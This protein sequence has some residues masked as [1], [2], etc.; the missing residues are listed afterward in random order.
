MITS[1]IRQH[2]VQ[3]ALIAAS[4]LLVHILFWALP[5]TFGVWNAQLV[6]RLFDIRLS[7]TSLKTPYD[8]TVIHVDLGDESLHRMGINYPERR[9][10][11]RVAKNLAQMGAARQFWDFIFSAPTSQEED[12]T[13][14]EAVGTAGNVYFGVALEHLSDALHLRQDEQSP[15]YQYLQRTAWDI[16]TH[17]SN[18]YI[19]QSFVGPTTFSALASVSAGL[20]AL[21]VKF[22]A[23]GVFRRAY[24]LQRLGDKYYPSLPLRVI[25]DYLQVKPEQMELTPGNSLLLHNAKFKN[26]P[27]KD[28][29][30]PIDRYG[31]TYINFNGPWQKTEADPRDPSKFISHTSM[32]HYDFADVYAIS[33]DQFAMED[34]SAFIR[35]KIVVVSLVSTGSSDVGPVP[36]D[37]NFP[38]SGFHANVMNTFLSG[39]FIR[40]ASIPLSFIVE[41]LFAV[42]LL[43]AS[44]RAS[45]KVFTVT[46]FALM[47]IFVILTIYAFL[48]FNLIFNIFGGSLA[49]VFS[50]L[51]ILAYRFVNEE[52]QK[53]VLRRSFESY[54]PPSVVKRI[55]A[56]PDMITS[57]G[58][59]KELT[60]LFSDIKGFTN[61]TSTVTPHEIQ[62]LLN[63]YFEAMV[64][65]VF[66]YEGTVDKFIGDGLMVFF[67]DPEPQPDHAIRGVR[68][69]IE[70]QKKCREFKRQWEQEGK[71]PIQ[72]RI[73]INTGFSIVGNM[74]SSKRLSYTVIGSEVNLAS[75]LESNAPVGGILISENTYSIVKDSVLTR[76]LGEI[77][78]KGLD[79]PVKVHE[80]LVDEQ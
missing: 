15:E 66:K 54:F 64:E 45:S 79:Q 4:F 40:D 73:G 23:D 1:K 50:S 69:A 6:D 7:T 11:A 53:E 17:G 36:T 39:S 78:V 58:Q 62:E 10:F 30:I 20:G 60:I 49:L 76:P 44:N 16:R 31:R 61:Y 52:K 38:L 24:I 33:D 72:I 55:M 65:I 57:A 13:L 26:D 8:S 71:M 77:K 67:G 70:M 59:K 41:F 9:H 3:A 27:P 18:A 68:A 12:S 37:N 14:F 25:C 29:A 46:S 34:F 47:V 75:R 42:V 43:F 63:K 56:N 19:P 28:I 35:G 32:L 51:N 21:T 5:D 74:G 48:Y 2:I 22:D 80:V